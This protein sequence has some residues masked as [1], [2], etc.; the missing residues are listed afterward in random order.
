MIFL[1]IN[2]Y[3]LL[4]FFQ[5]EGEEDTEEQEGEETLDEEENDECSESF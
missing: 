4:N 3:L 5:G 2:V 1:L